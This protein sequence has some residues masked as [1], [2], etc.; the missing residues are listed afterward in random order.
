MWGLKRGLEHGKALT[1][2]GYTEEADKKLGGQCTLPIQQ[3][4]G[5]LTGQRRKK[6]SFEWR[7]NINKNDRAMT[8][9]IY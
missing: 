1:I 5:K 9:N 2:G 3:A 7:S 8:M 6:N 4:V